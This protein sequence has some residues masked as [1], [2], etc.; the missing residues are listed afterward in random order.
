MRLSRLLLAL[1]M[2]VLCPAAAFALEGGGWTVRPGEW[3]TEV[4]A[5]RASAGAQFLTDARDVA[6]PNNGRFQQVLLRSYSE[7]GWKKNASLLLDIP[8]ET[9]SWRLQ[10]QTS[11]VSGISDVTVGLRVRLRDDAPGLILDLGWRAPLGYD[12]NVFPSL[13]D[14]RQKLYTS[15][16]GGV[17]LP[18]LPGFAQASRGILFVS[19][20]GVVFSQTT[21]DAAVWLGPNVLFGGRYAD[22][23]AWNSASEVRP[24]PTL[25]AAGPVMVV[26]IDDRMD[27]S[28]AA[29]RR[30]YG[31]NSLEGTQITVALGMKQT[32]L[33]PLQGFLGVKK[34]P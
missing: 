21:A 18:G 33:G 28:V 12:K 26:R 32:K 2:A 34:H 20:D 5:A 10:R 3:Y 7:I 15:I 31:R 22:Q 27:L 25:Y 16:N 29:M 24:L 9:R 23:V 17:K 4:G 8:F 6:I 1:L 14:G 13:G 30:L 11:S 19:E